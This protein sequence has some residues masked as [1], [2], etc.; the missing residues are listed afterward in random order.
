MGPESDLKLMF[1]STTF[2]QGTLSLHSISTPVVVADVPVMFV[3]MISD[4]ETADVCSQVKKKKIKPKT[5]VKNVVVSACRHFLDHN[6]IQ[7]CCKTYPV[8]T[9]KLTS[10]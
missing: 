9:G 10:E 8:V 6:P 7:K 5:W 2:L 4:T 1:C 3:K